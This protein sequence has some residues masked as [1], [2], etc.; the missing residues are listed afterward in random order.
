MASLLLAAKTKEAKPTTVSS[1]TKI[2]AAISLKGR[3]RP[4]APH[5][6]ALA[7]RLPQPPR[8]HAHSVLVPYE[9][10]LPTCD[11]ESMPVFPLPQPP[12]PFERFMLPPPVPICYTQP[13]K[14]VARYL[15]KCTKLSQ[16]EVR[17]PLLA[18][19][20]NAMASLLLAAKMKEAKP[21]TVSSETKIAAAISLKGRTRP[22]APHP[23]AL[24]SRLPQPPRPHAHSVLVPYETPPPTCDVESIPVFPLPQPPR[25]SK[26]L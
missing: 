11:V 12:R 1:E 26:Q 18:P 2:A 14:N 24:A 22:Q 5:P 4:Q 21:T 25:P 19:R 16:L 15:R 17:T 8:P 13:C 7:S 23:D 20:A 3:T 6:D 10:P 9:T